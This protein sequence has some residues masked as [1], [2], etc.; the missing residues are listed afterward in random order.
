MN[1]VNLYGISHCDTMKKARQWLRAQ[2]IEYRFHDY[3]KQ[4]VDAA[5]LSHWADVVGW[6]Q[7]L[8][9]RGTTWRGLSDQD[10]A[11]TD[12][13]KAIR[14]MLANP[15]LIRRPVLATDGIVEVGFSPTRYE[16]LFR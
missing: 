9:R 11:D 2:D 4:G 15:S 10:R 16:E 3:K 5:M 1:Q 7:L 13:D 6:E 12:R 14:L 8:N